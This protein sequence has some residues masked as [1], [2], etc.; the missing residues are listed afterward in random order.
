MG[1]GRADSAWP[2]SPLQ[3]CVP[4]ASR[5][6][7]QPSGWRIVIDVY[8]GGAAAECVAGV[9]KRAACDEAEFLIS[10]NTGFRVD[11][12]DRGQKVVRLT[13]ED[14]SHCLRSKPRRRCA[15]HGAR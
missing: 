8:G 5:R 13:L 12:V 1:P 11:A 7:A 15:R 3:R 4:S 9:H 6:F 10:A 2:L 14:E